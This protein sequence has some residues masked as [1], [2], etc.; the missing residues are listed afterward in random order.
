MAELVLA[1]DLGTG[2]CKASLYDFSGVCCGVHFQPYATRYSRPGYH[3]QRPVDW[4]QAV[5]TSARTL[6]AAGGVDAVSVR[7]I[8]ISGFSLGV[9]PLGRKNELLLDWVPIWS[10]SRSLPRD[11]DAVFRSIPEE[12]WYEITGNGFPPALYT[13]FKIIWLRNESPDIFNKMCVVLGSKD[14]INFLLTGVIATDHSYAS[15][16]GAYNLE[17]RRYSEPILRASSLSYSML[18]EVISSTQVLGKLL[19]ESARTLGLSSDV[20]VV[21][22]GVDNSCMALGCRNIEEGSIYAS[23]GSS[24]WIAVT[25]SKPII[26][27]RYRPYVFEHVIPGLYNSATSIFSAG[28]SYKWMLN[29]ICRDLVDPSNPDAV[30]ERAEA[31]ANVVPA[32]SRGLIFN[33]SLAGGNAIDHSLRIAGA[34]LGLSLEHSRDDMIRA[35]LEGICMGLKRAF[36]FLS[37]MT[38]VKKE[39]IVAGGGAKSRLWRQMLANVL[40]MSVIKTSIDQQAAAL[41][42][43]ALAAV[44]TR[45]WRDF[46]RI[47]ELHE[48][49]ER[50]DPEPDAVSAYAK[51]SLLHNEANRLLSG[52][53]DFLSSAP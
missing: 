21:S 33:P 16:S 32:G 45:V 13:L 39:M 49:R 46:T 6:V 9:V 29:Q 17:E 10:D 35:T 31:L 23:L 36:S 19:P 44:G 41:G 27:K 30:Y 42:A 3:E 26:D 48:L 47:A 51:L 34:W 2:G 28:S 8:G 38:P 22:G 53:G 11:T 20:M 1:I 18:P 5:I 7:S 50:H 43:A 25:S 37:S 40:D 4:W 15:G 14:Y 12:T 52:F 24:S